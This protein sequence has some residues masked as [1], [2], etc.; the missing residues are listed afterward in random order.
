MK[1]ALDIKF[2]AAMIY[3][4]KDIIESPKATKAADEWDGSFSRSERLVR[5]L[6]REREEESFMKLA[7]EMIFNDRLH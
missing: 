2:K 7:T 6:S 3:L 1:D 5:V 4:N